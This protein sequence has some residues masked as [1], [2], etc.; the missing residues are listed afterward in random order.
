MLVSYRSPQSAGR[1]WR[2][3][4]GCNLRSGCHPGCPLLPD[5]CHPG[6]DAEVRARRPPD[7]GVRGARTATCNKSNLKLNLKLNLELNLNPKN[8]S[9]SSIFFYHGMVQLAVLKNMYVKKYVHV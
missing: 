4:L 3:C 6:R 5:C 9:I 2:W 8:T 1:E 7:T